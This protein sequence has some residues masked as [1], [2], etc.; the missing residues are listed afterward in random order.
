[1]AERIVAVIVSLE[2]PRACADRREHALDVLPAS[3]GLGDVVHIVAS[4]ERG[5]SVVPLTARRVE[6]RRYPTALSGIVTESSRSGLIIR[7]LPT[8]ERF[9]R[10]GR[11]DAGG[12][13]LRVGDAV[14][15]TA[16][17]DDGRAWEVTRAGARIPR[18]VI[19][20]LPEV[21]EELVTERRAWAEDASGA[22][23]TGRGPRRSPL[24]SARRVAGDASAPPGAAPGTRWVLLYAGR[25]VLA[26]TVRNRSLHTGRLVLDVDPGDVGAAREVLGERARLADPAWTLRTEAGD[27]VSP[28]SS[29]AEHRS[30]MPLPDDPL[31]LELDLSGG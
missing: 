18:D 21:A 31:A 15:F 16:M 3:V 25:R 27:V 7:E 17:A 6:G 12:G 22:A 24:G 4:G 20:E 9:R 19:E 8:L 29:L 14:R 26:A 30:V 10:D 23:R 5:S 28:A 13:A 1:M 2:P 11:R